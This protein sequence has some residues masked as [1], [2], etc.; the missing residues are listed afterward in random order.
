[1]GISSSDD[2]FHMLGHCLWPLN[3][4][5]WIHSKKDVILPKGGS[6]LCRIKSIVL[7][8]AARLSRNNRAH[9]QLATTASCGNE[10]GEAQIDICIKN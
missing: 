7:N 2:L 8:D 5:C 10:I 9:R 1:M 3:F 4:Y 6:I